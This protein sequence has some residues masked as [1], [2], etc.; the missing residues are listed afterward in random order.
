LAENVIKTALNDI[1]LLENKE[2]YIIEPADVSAGSETINWSVAH[3]IRKYFQDSGY[4]VKFQ[5]RAKLN[6][7][8]ARECLNIGIFGK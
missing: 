1:S 5:T 4:I 7:P 8:T 2:V 3:I 6:N